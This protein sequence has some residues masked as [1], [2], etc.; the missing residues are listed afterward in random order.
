MEIV[1]TI[2]SKA[3]ALVFAINKA[4]ENGQT[5]DK[6][7]VDEIYDYILT[8]VTLP[9]L[10]TDARDEYMNMLGGMLDKY[11]GMMEGLTSEIKA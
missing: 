3:D 8:K 4:T 1:T 9:D 2:K 5:F 7:K 11:T 6:E 10:E